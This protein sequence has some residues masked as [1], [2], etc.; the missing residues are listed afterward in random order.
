MTLQTLRL[1][2]NP[3]PTV[4]LNIDQKSTWNEPKSHASSF[5]WKTDT[6]WCYFLSRRIRLVHRHAVLDRHMDF[7]MAMCPLP[8][9]HLLRGLHPRCQWSTQI[10]PPVN[11]VGC[12]TKHWRN[13]ASCLFS[14]WSADHWAPRL[15]PLHRQVF[16][17]LCVQIDDTCYVCRL[18][19]CVYPCPR[20]TSHNPG[21]TYILRTTLGSLHLITTYNETLNRQIVLW[22]HYALDWAFHPC[23]QGDTNGNRGVEV[24]LISS[25]FVATIE[26]NLWRGVKTG[27]YLWELLEKSFF[28]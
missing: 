23:R 25:L 7:M 15:S 18:M 20:F 22:I 8:R 24:G 26:V 12:G 16:F 2:L 5:L 4:S 19:T 21:F 27:R 6:P 10:S 11:T 14:S 28:I 13:T 3:P 1:F 9:L 17:L